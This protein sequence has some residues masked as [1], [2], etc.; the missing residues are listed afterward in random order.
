MKKH[1][2]DRYDRDDNGAV[3]INISA[4]KIK[5]LYNDFDKE[6]S[7]SK[8]DLDEELVEYII[9]SVKEIGNE[10]FVIKFYFDEKL[11][12]ELENR[13][14]NSILNFFEYLQELEKKAMKEQIKNAMI[15][16]VIGVFFT[17]ASLSFGRSNGEENVFYEVISE[18]LLVAG[19]VSLWESLAT[20]LIKWLPLSKK[21]KIYKKIALSR[22]EFD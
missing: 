2:L 15:F 14:K 16:M 9:D 4:K 6:S 8:K 22:V 10:E 3:V 5:D 19:W 7:F 17:A 12:D 13:I 1:I 20:F 21:L 18:G 11:N